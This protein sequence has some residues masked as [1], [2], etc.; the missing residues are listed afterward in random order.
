ML[1]LY[2]V[3]VLLLAGCEIPARAWAPPMGPPGR[4]VAERRA[5]SRVLQIPMQAV[6]PRVLD[7]LLDAGCVVRAADRELGMVSFFRV[8]ADHGGAFTYS[9][10]GTLLFRSERPG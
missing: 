9:Q 10:E 6:F 8:W 1:R 5:R 2:G 3:L 4:V 7:V